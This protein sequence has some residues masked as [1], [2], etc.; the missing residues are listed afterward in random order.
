M[1][2]DAT[3]GSDFPRLVRK[4]LQR[5]GLKNSLKATREVGPS[6]LKDLTSGF[7]RQTGSSTPGTE[8][9]NP[10]ETRGRHFNLA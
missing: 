4:G 9:A 5:V 2:H 10:Y 8:T 3:G 1:G 6:L 7:T